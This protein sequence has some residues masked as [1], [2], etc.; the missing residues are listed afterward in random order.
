MTDTAPTN[1]TGN[2][3]ATLQVP[4]AD[5][6]ERVLFL[7]AVG[8]AERVLWKAGARVLGDQRAE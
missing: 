3:T 1:A 4:G 8:R 6:Q 2:P 5:R 7:V